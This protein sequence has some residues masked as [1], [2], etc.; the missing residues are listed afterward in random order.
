MNITSKEAKK[1]LDFLSK[2]QGANENMLKYVYLGTI[3]V[4]LY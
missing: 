3:R 1:K 2:L 4:G